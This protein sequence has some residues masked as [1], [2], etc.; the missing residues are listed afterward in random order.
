MGAIVLRQPFGGMGKSVFGPGMKAGG[1]NYVALLMDFQDG[2]C[3]DFRMSE[4]GTVP[5]ADGHHAVVGG[6]SAQEGDESG[7]RYPP[8]ALA[9]PMPAYEPMIARLC[10]QLRQ[11]SAGPGTTQWSSELDIA[12]V[13]RAAAS[14][15]T[16]FREEF[17]LSHDHFKLIGQDNVRRYLPVR[18]LRIRVHPQD[19]L[20]SI[21]ARL[22]AARVAGCRTTVSAPPDCH[23]AA[24]QRLEE[25]TEPWAGAVEF[26]EET[27]AELAA[28]VRARQTDRIRYA[29]P[30]VL[31]PSYRKRR[32]K[33]ACTLPPSRSP[34]RAAASCSGTSRSRASASTITGTATSASARAS[35]ER[36]CHDRNLAAEIF[37]AR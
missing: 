12:Q 23:R 11:T 31:R 26:V 2:D 28:V 37:G 15:T 3:P 22:C 10:E 25:L 13:R 1:P 18:E 7:A 17:G 33:R 27:D 30:T 8:G 20:L 36:R 24:L 21:S 19:S 9:G 35:R 5:F 32:P 6:P 4:K 29:A 34:W 14:Y 16:S